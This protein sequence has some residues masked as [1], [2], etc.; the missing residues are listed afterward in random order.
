VKLVLEVLQDNQHV[1]REASDRINR[2]VR[3]LKNFARLDQ[4]ERQEADLNQGLE[5]TLA[6]VQHEFGDRIR[7]VRD[8]GALP[9]VLRHPGQLNQL[10]MNLLVNAS[11]AI[12]GQGTVTIS[13][14]VDGDSV[15][16]RVKDSGEGI[17]PDHL[18][19]IFDPGFTTTAA[20]P[21]HVRRYSSV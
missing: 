19:K 13:T 16:I 11:Q 2:L 5:S 4:A 9:R 7:V 15:A 17:P 8:F 12:T 6:V 10:F 18:S 21:A 1:I 20:T 14:V 3:S